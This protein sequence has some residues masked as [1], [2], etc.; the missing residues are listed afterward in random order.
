MNKLTEKVFE[1]APY[2]DTNEAECLCVDPAMW[3]VTGGEEQ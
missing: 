3:H 1:C 2:G